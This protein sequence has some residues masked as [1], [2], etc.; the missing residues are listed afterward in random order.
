[1][2]EQERMARTLRHAAPFVSVARDHGKAFLLSTHLLGDVERVCDTVLILH[3]GR[4]LLQG[5]VAEL[6]RREVELVEFVVD[7]AVQGS[8]ETALQALM[9]DPMVNDIDM[10]RAILDDYLTTHAQHLPQFHGAPA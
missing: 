2:T 8:R 1:M 5:G 3:Q 10:A 7:A 4:L 9:L 6:C